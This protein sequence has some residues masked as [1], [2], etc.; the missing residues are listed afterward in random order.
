[1]IAKSKK[2]KRWQE[3]KDKFYQIL[4][5]IFTLL[6]LSALIF[7]NWKI[8]QKRAE[9]QTKVKF[10]Q[11]EIKRLE[12]E[13]E[14]YENEVLEIDKDEYWKRLLKEDWGYKELNEKVV[15]FVPPKEKIEP[16]AKEN[17]E[18]KSSFF[19]VVKQNIAGLVEWFNITF[20]R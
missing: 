13:K 7:S 2:L 3:V 16:S 17:S 20:P 18:I 14:K 6:I 1:M 12:K 4:L 8:S 9:F 19:E 5:S 15:V 11:E 10:L